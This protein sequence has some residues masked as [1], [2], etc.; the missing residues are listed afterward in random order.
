MSQ[1]WQLTVVLFITLVLCIGAYTQRAVFKN[2]DNFFY[3]LLL[4]TTAAGNVS[5]RITIIDIDETSLSAVGQWPWPRYLLAKLV[6]ELFDNQPAAMGLD[7]LLPEPDRSSLKNIQLQFRKDFALNLGFTGVPPAMQDNDLYLAHIFRQADI[8]GARYFYFDHF[9]KKASPLRVPFDV[10]DKSGCL[11]ANQAEG[12][13]TNT[14]QIETALKYTGFLNSQ[15]DMDGLLRST[16]LLISLKGQTF[17]NLSLST[18]LKAHNVKKLEVLENFF[19]LYIKADKYKIPITRDGYLHMRFS[20]PGRAHKFIGAADILNQNYSPADIQGK[21]LFIGSSATGLNDIH[22]TVFDP[23]YPGLEIHAAILSSIYENRQVIKPIWSHAFISGGLMFTG[24]LMMFLLFFSASPMVLLAGTMVWGSILLISSLLCFIKIS[25]FISPVLPFILTVFTFVFTSF[26]RFTGAR[27][28]SFAW[29]KKLAQ[30][31]QFTIK[32]IVGLVETRDPETGQH[33]VRTQKYARALVVHLK[34]SGLF[35]DILTDDYIETLYHASPLHDI[36]KV[37]I[38]DRILLKPGKLTDEEFEIMKTHSSIGRDT[39]QRTGR[40]DQG[41]YFLKM[42][43]LIA[44]S[45]HERW[46]GKGYPDG[47]C[48]ENI[49]LCGRIMAICDVYD[50]LISKR[51]YKPA[52]SHEKAMNIILVGRGSMFDPQFIDGFFAIEDTIKLIAARHK[53]L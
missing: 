52:F 28:A 7:I 41:N 50:A 8:V 16:P 12:V 9:N 19:G 48:G 32:T 2:A 22:H 3:D 20:G 36:G 34:K 26:V 45:H 1:W 46:D 35:P 39:L 4:Q 47:L 49:P 37:G 5:S 24:I 53:D 18:F 14:P 33:I 10:V 25:V 30:A 13:L 42:G 6:K 44:G 38:P 15:S 21:I 29:F 27:K 43:A 40:N 31:Q 23:S 17:T 11:N 51:C